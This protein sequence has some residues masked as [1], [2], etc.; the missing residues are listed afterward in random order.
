MPSQ[1]KEYIMNTQERKIY[2]IA[3]FTAD[4]NRELV[5]VALNGLREYLD[6][7]P[8]IYVQAFDCFGFA[9][10]SQDDFYKYEIYELPDLKNY[11][12]VVVQAHQIMDDSALRRL[13]DRIEE[14]GIPA[15]S[16]GAKMKGCIYIGTDD[17]NSMK[18]I[19]EHLITLHKAR[20]FLYLKGAEREGYGEAYDRRRGF[21]DTCD[22]YG[23]AKED[24][25]YYDGYWQSENGK[26]AVRAWLADG[27]PLP[28][29][30]VASNDEM[31]LG[32]MIAL[33]EEGYHIPKDVLVTGVDDI[34]TAS[35]S[36]PRLTTVR[37]DFHSIIMIAMDALMSRICGNR[38]PTKIYVPHEA[39]FSESCG[40]RENNVSDLLKLKKRYYA[41]SRHMEKF[42]YLQDQMTA[43]I[44][45]PEN[46]LDILSAAE[47]YLGIFG[48]GN[49]YLYIN[50]NYYDSFMDPEAS[51][52]IGT[53]KFSDTFVLAAQ[54]SIS[55]SR[56]ETPEDS[57]AGDFAETK[58]A[59]E[60]KVHPDKILH[61]K[62]LATAA[63]LAEEPFTLF[64]PLH[65]KNTMMGFLALN[66]PPNL[67][68]MNLHE[69]IS[70]LLVFAIENG[71]QKL[72]ARNLNDKLDRLCLT[73]SLTE[74]YNRFGYERFSEEMFTDMKKKGNFIRVLFLDIDDMKGINDRFGHENGDLALRTLSRIIRNS[75]RQEDF[76]MRY[77]G[78]EFVIITRDCKGD[79][80]SRVKDKI[81][82]CNASGELP[83]TL[84]ASIG[85]VI[86]NAEELESL[87]ELLVMAD[88]QMYQE[89]KKRKSQK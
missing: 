50:R 54:S 86:S 47:K 13:E 88:E 51:A 80:K 40:C 34:F 59:G 20:T 1:A 57:H 84:Q 15:I 70:N 72:V 75:C 85:E 39:I 63:P 78:D 60:T 73:D 74:L 68:E 30:I 69:S 4:W 14:A 22:R 9:L 48:G 29:A 83:F 49:V 5:S 45:G 3:Y 71:R 65:F 33:K 79:I 61:R 36:D 28:D 7:H 21:E 6:S 64:Y 24:I 42:Y 67:S 43:G 31:A 58:A 26:K 53:R 23:I 62:E 46:P 16:I 8:D 55:Q 76:K 35:L 2:R 19:T 12:A 11:D 87:D 10:H 32:V 56:A 27:K 17:Y 52:G 77:G 82:Q 41:H 25:H 89:K 66:Q 44:L 38:V 18:S 37:R 81:A